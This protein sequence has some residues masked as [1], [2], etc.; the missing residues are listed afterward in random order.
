MCYEHGY[1]PPRTRV[2]QNIHGTYVPLV[3]SSPPPPPTSLALQL[4][5]ARPVNCTHSIRPRSA[6][7]ATKHSPY[8]VGSHALYMNSHFQNSSNPRNSFGISNRRISINS[9]YPMRC[10]SWSSALPPLHVHTNQILCRLS[11]TAVGYERSAC[12]CTFPRVFHRSIQLA[13]SIMDCR[14]HTY[15]LTKCKNAY[16][17]KNYNRTPLW[18]ILTLSAGRRAWMLLRASYLREYVLVKSRYKINGVLHIDACTSACSSDE[19]D[20]KIP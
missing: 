2:Y 11:P 20:E 13:S 12:W 19:D 15:I 5:C 8:P 4:I 1:A 9:L 3:L 17:R 10:V 16:T 14:I 7:N 6:I 18:K